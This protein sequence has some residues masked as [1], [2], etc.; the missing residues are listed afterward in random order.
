MAAIHFSD[1][2]SLIS[3]FG[4]IAAV[5]AA[6]FMH[7]SQVRSSEAK[8][9]RVSALASFRV[10]SSIFTLLTQIRSV[11]LNV[12][13]VETLIMDKLDIHR[14]F[15]ELSEYCQAIS[16]SSIAA[17]SIFDHKSAVELAEGL[18][19]I[20]SL[21][22]KVKVVQKSDYWKNSIPE[23]RDKHLSGWDSELTSAFFKIEN[24]TSFMQYLSATDHDVESQ[25]NRRRDVRPA[26]GAS[27]WLIRRLVPK[28]RN[29]K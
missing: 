17:L 5:V 7:I 1:W 12:R 20:E 16:N 18:G 4:T 3:A 14:E 11:Q 23:H 9:K 2:I 13:S 19:K 24:S 15:L 28:S 26:D 6:L 22:N 21:A 8:E 27:F 29:P 25:V 10:A